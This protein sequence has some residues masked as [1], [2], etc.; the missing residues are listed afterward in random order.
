[1]QVDISLRSRD[2]KHVHLVHTVFYI[3]NL[4]VRTILYSAVQ[5]EKLAAAS[6]YRQVF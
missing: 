2:K 1:M 5:Y 4:I 3:N 6:T